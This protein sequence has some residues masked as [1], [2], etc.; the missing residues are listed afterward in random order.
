MPPET[1]AAFAVACGGW[2]TAFV[3]WLRSRRKDRV[4]AAETVVQAAIALVAPL[5]ARVEALENSLA[6]ANRRI[7]SLELENATLRRQ[8]A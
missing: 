3:G 2:G 1:I 7:T 4:D 8:L 6:A 5:Q